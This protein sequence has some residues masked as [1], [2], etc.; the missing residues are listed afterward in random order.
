MKTAFAVLIGIGIGSF[1]LAAEESLDP[2]VPAAKPALLSPIARVGN[3]EKWFCT[4]ARI[5]GTNYVLTAGHCLEDETSFRVQP[6]GGEPLV[7]RL[8]A[9]S[10]ASSGL[11]DWALVEIEPGIEWPGATLRCSPEA[12][13]VGTEISAAGYP[14]FIGTFVT[15]WGRISA[16]PSV[17]RF[18]PWTWPVYTAQMPVAPGDSGGPVFAP[19]GRVF[20]IMVGYSAVQPSWSQLQP[21]TGPICAALHLEDKT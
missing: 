5:A 16:P 17:I 14:G 7:A 11:E 12:L 9:I 1:A 10:L 20:A 15:S 4:G 18:S 13:P 2:A 3:Y 21:V 6:E 8:A 19:D